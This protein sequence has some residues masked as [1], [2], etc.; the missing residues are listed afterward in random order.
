MEA[1]ILAYQNITARQ[2]VRNVDRYGKVKTEQQKR[3]LV[4]LHKRRTTDCK[5]AGSK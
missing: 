4:V 3:T 2:Y 1:I 5:S